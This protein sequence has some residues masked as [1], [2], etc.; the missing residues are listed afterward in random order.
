MPLLALHPQNICP[1]ICLVG[2]LPQAMAARFLRSSWA[3]SSSSLGTCTQQTV[4]HVG[5]SGGGCFWR[6]SRRQSAT[7]AHKRQQQ[8]QQHA[9]S[10]MIQ[11]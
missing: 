6:A 2:L 10:C 1:A 5:Q 11:R 8:Q 9:L 7:E 4:Q 3:L